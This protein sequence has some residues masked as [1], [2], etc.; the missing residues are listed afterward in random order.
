MT[1]KQANQEVIDKKRVAFLLSMILCL[2]VTKIHK[3]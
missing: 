2:S 3:M 1:N